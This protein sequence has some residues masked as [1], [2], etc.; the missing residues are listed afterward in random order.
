MRGGVHGVAASN[1]PR[2]LNTAPP[3]DLAAFFGQILVRMDA[4]LLAQDKAHGKPQHHR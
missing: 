4:P 2:G 1:L 3:S